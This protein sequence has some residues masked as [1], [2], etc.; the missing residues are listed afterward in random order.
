M[1]EPT[2]V[3]TLGRFV[4]A[5][6]SEAIPDGTRARAVVSLLHNLVVA[7]A[8]RGRYPAAEL[9]AR[10]FHAQPA[11][12]T[13]LACGSKVE[14]AAAAMAN[15]ALFHARSQDD[16][17][18]GST[19]HPGAP[20]MAAAL[21][22]AEETGASGRDVLDAVILGYEV[23]GRVGSDIHEALTG[24]GF[25]AAAVLGGFGAA[26]ASARLMG[27]DAAQT[28]HALAFAAHGAGGLS[29]V[30]IE[31]S[32]EYPM[33]LG[34]GARHGVE[35]ARLASCGMTAAR[36][37]LEGSRGFDLAYAG[38]AAAPRRILSGLGVDWQMD[39]ATVKP[40]PA[41]A[42]LQG[43]LEALRDGLAPGERVQQIA[44]HLPPFEAAYPGI[45][46]P[47]PVW[48][49]PGAT[50]MSAQFCLGVMALDG[51][52]RLADLSRLDDPA[53]AAMAGRVAVRSDPALAAR[54]CRIEVAL[55]GGDTRVLRVARAAGQPDV[56]G[57]RRFA[58][59][60]AEDMAMTPE[61]VAQLVAAVEGLDTA[62][63]VAAL[64]RAA[65]A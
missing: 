25:R 55:D 12:A 29:Q 14:P 15:G 43:P 46:N 44:L 61:T 33:Q 54:L 51:R 3:E 30:W 27:L 57:I 10:R 35:A 64:M 45:D 9:V 39:A 42:I 52:L 49:S 18:P 28:A 13:L 16:T 2:L 7:R 59:D 65:T 11:I 53:I 50:K 60:M 31:G 56:A 47:G 38:G 1:T 48:P 34:Q 37:I 20:V 6:P 24:R 36:A 19:S 32:A 40:F 5:T 58:L 41:C 21:A 8:G 17:H 22:V 62:P 23:L 4:A 26:A 63:N